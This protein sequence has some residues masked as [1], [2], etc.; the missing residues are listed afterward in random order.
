MAKN[1]LKVGIIGTG[2]AAQR[3]AEALR[4]DTRTEPLYFTGNTEANSQSFA[5]AYN[6]TPL[7]SWQKLVNHPD[8]DLIVLATINQDHEMLTRAALE[9]G[10]HVIVEYPLAF[11]AQ[12]GQ[13]LLDL[14]Q[15]RGKL[16]HIEHIELLGGLHQAILDNLPSIGKVYYGRYSTL[17]PQS[18]APLR[19]SY[20]REMFGFPLIAA[21]SRIH[22]WTNLFGQVV[23]VSGHCQF[24]DADIP[25]FFT[26]CLCDAQLR[27]SDGMIAQITYGKGDKLWQNERT[28]TLYGEQGVLFFEGET[29]KLIRPQET[30]P[31][32][33]GKRQGLFNKDTQLVL[34][35]LFEEKPLYVT[36]EQSL[37]ALKVAEGARISSLT[38]KTMEIPL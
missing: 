13:S 38:G 27:F 30:I 16:L 15:K 6:L 26:A 12:A 36:A 32:E 2:Y 17:M 11:S 21:L 3:R 20:N 8:L 19:W 35:H 29:G 18:P 22:R 1:P 34:D 23:S 4:A 9:A 5:Q 33:V 31:V 24:W 7:D 14:A 28:F 25:N 37:Y 10:K